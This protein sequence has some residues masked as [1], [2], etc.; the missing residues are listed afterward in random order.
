MKNKGAHTAIAFVGE[1]ENSGKIMSGADVGIAMGSL[2]SDSALA[3]ADV[4]IMDRDI[5]KISENSDDFSSC[6]PVLF[7]V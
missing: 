2:G 3:S 6:L 1:G 7:T 5:F 4:M